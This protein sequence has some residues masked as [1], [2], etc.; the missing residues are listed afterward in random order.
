M[1]KTDNADKYENLKLNNQ[2]CFLLYVGAKGIINLYTPYLKAIDLT[3]TQYIVMMVLWEHKQ[4]LTRHLKERLYLD[5][6]TLTP[7]LNRL[8]QK[9]F[10]IK[11]RSQD[12]A[13]DLLVSITELG[14]N[15]KDKAV[16][17]P[18]SIEICMQK[19]EY[20]RELKHMLESMMEILK[21]SKNNIQNNGLLGGI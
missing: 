6:G 13:R 7:V 11:N 20:S 16:K 4:I 17:I 9:R 10:I 12:D 18:E 14:E 2:L 15:L 21:E 3:Y 1:K 8:E 5:S 19:L